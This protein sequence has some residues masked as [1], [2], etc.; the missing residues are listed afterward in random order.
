MKATKVG[1]ERRGRRPHLVRPTLL[2]N[3]P[4]CAPSRASPTGVVVHRLDRRGD[5]RRSP[6]PRSPDR[7]PR[8]SSRC[9][10]LIVDVVGDAGELARAAPRP[11]RRAWPVPLKKSGSPNVMCCGARRRPARDVGQH[12][13][14]IDDAEAAR[15]TRAP[16][17]SAGTGACTRGWLRCSRHAPRAI[18]PDERG[19]AC[20]ARADRGDQAR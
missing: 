5:E 16:R 3:P 9:S 19:V 10:I 1:D 4:A 6:C 18:G 11:R 8:C 7:C 20:R 2:R 13:V 17:D 12:H 15:H 14:G